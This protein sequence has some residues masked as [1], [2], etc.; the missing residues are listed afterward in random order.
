MI[1]Y[2]FQVGFSAIDF[3]SQFEELE[4]LY[5]ALEEKAPKKAREIMNRHIEHFIK[6]VKDNFFE[7]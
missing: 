7:L 4:E 2:W 6:L 5:V 1:M 3:Q